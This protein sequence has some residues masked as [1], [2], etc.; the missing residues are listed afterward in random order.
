MKIAKRTLILASALSV[1]VLAPP[2]RAD[3]TKTND[4]YGTPNETYNDN[5]YYDDT[6]LD[7]EFFHSRL[8]PHGSWLNSRQ[9]GLVW[10][11]RVHEQGWHPYEHGRWQ[12]SDVGWVWV[13]DYRWGAIPYHYGTWVKDQQHDWVWVPGTTWAPA[14]VVF[15]QNQDVI[16]WAPVAP[17][18]TVGGGPMGRTVEGQVS[19]PFVYVPTRYF[20]AGPLNKYLIPESRVAGLARS[21]RVINSLRIE[22][23]MVVNRVPDIRLIQQAS[24]RQFRPVPV[25]RIERIAPFQSVQRE[26]LAIQGRGQVRAAVP[27]R[28]TA[29]RIQFRGRPEVRD[30]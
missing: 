8:S 25:E 27:V 18:F 2:A 11:P 20:A 19:G 9:Y 10:Q 28:E 24:G 1:A 26:Q 4:R 23:G 29:R 12:Y 7:L 30:Q 5:S 17:S 14:W 6:N 15:R 13:S 22:N 21:T 3:H 16:G